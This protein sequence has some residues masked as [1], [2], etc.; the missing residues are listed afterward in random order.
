M[1]ELLQEQVDHKPANV[2][3][4]CLHFQKSGGNHCTTVVGDCLMSR[5][6]SKCSEVV[7]DAIHHFQQQLF[8]DAPPDFPSSSTVKT[9][10]LRQRFLWLGLIS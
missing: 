9:Q 3:H 10:N 7:C 5:A 6:K 4:F 1:L 8:R 2:Q